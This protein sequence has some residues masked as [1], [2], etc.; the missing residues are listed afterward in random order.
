MLGEADS[1]RCREVLQSTEKVS[2][3]SSFLFV[4][5]ANLERPLVRPSKIIS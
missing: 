3:V 5:G 4:R 1:C 2:Q